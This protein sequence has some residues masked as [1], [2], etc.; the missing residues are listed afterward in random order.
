VPSHFTEI[1]YWRLSRGYYNT[2]GGH[3]RI[4]HPRVLAARLREA[5]LS[6]TRVRYVHF[7]D[8]LVWLRFCLTDFLRPSKPASGYEA[9]IL[10]AVAA[11]ARCRRGA[12][13]APPSAARDS[14]PRS[15]P[16]AP[17]LAQELHVRRPQE[18]PL[19]H[20]DTALEQA[21][22]VTNTRP[23]VA[24]MDEP[25]STGMPGEVPSLT[26]TGRVAESFFSSR[27]GIDQSVAA[28]LLAVAM[29]KGGE[30]AE[31]FFEH[32]EGSNIT[33][34]QQA[35]KSASRSKTQGVG[36]RVIQGDAIGYAYTEDLGRD[37]M[38]RAADTPPARQPRRQPE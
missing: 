12:R 33:F 32:R 27:Y 14:S 34:E 31:L 4:Y 17:R 29:S 6:I 8:S 22:A 11:N 24:I 2:P 20:A 7:I 23:P 37:A 36:I 5:G 10:L 13:C 16:R 3:V 19:I 18:P 9:A 1:V 30:H 21:I 38:R 15:T 25:Q 35:V 26:D 28:D